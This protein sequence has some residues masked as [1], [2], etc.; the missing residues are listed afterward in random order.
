MAHSQTVH[1]SMP[2][3]QFQG[4]GVW[5]D[6]F[7]T[8]GTP[9][10]AAAAA[11]CLKGN[12]DSTGLG[13]RWFPY[14]HL[15]EGDAISSLCVLPKREQ[16][17]LPKTF[18]HRLKQQAQLSTRQREAARAELVGNGQLVMNDPRSSAFVR[19][20]ELSQLSQR[21]GGDMQIYDT[22]WG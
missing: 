3:I 22:A 1:T 9:G 21:G 7:P 8:A 12:A 19:E 10:N 18:A 16:L 13:R 11:V 20:M 5:H 2:Q 17:H 6:C 15:S 4:D 14:F